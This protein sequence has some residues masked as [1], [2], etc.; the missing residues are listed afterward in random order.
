MID[1]S[2][3]KGSFLFFV[4]LGRLAEWSNALHL[5]CSVQQCT[6][7]SNPTSSA[8]GVCHPDVKMPDGVIGNTTGFG[9]VILGS[10]PNRV[11]IPPS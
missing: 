3:H 5:K 10:S 11:T 6:V 8:I 4:F 7:G 1:V 9:P 2:S